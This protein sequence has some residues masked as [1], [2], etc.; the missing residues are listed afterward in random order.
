MAKKEVL[1]LKLTS[2]PIPRNF[3]MRELDQLLSKCGCYKT[4]GG[5]GSSVKYIDPST[6]RVL[7]FDKPHPGNELYPYHIEKVLCF[8]KEIGEWKEGSNEHVDRV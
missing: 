8:L 1:L 7:T 6:K 3:T 2:K 5:R 4:P